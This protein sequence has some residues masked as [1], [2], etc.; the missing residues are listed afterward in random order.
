M[1]A[2][3]T[4]ELHN[5]HTAKNAPLWIS[6]KV[7]TF[8]GIISLKGCDLCLSPHAFC[9]SRTGSAV[10][11]S[12]ENDKSFI[13]FY[14]STHSPDQ[15]DTKTLYFSVLVHPQMKQ[16]FALLYAALHLFWLQVCCLLP[17][18][19][20]GVSISINHPVLGSFS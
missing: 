3:F 11:R 16:W 18:W 6:L 10:S 13:R 1:S 15:T 17:S 7:T 20:G 19:I 2:H 5:K 4:S 12:P 14:R 9:Y 8:R